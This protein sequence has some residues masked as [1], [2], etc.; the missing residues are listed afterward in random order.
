MD[1]LMP[2]PGDYDEEDDSFDDEGYPIDPYEDAN[3]PDEEEEDEDD[4]YYPDEDEYYPGE[5]DEPDVNGEYIRREFA[6]PGG[7]SALRAAT[8]SNP[9]IYPCPTCGKPNR[10]TLKDVRLKYQ[11]DQCSDL[12]EMG[13]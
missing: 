2:V 7:R 8:K 13:F 11:C 12:A 5:G 1:K 10:L 3:L 9:R 6:D 4:D